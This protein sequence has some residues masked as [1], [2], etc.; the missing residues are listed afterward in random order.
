MAFGI[1]TGK[2]LAAYPLALNA[3]GTCFGR[4]GGIYPLEKDSTQEGLELYRLLHLR[5]EP[6]YLPEG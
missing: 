3:P 5:K 2:E 4:V 1:P 6:M